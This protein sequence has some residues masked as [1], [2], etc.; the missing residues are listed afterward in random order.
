MATLT[1]KKLSQSELYEKYK[2]IG[3]NRYIEIAIDKLG[4]SHLIIP[5]FQSDNIIK[6]DESN[7]LYD[8]S[9]ELKMNDISAELRNIVIKRVEAFNFDRITDYWA[10]YLDAMVLGLCEYAEDNNVKIVLI[11]V[12]FDTTENMF[13]AG[14]DEIKYDSEVMN[15]NITPKAK[16]KK[17]KKVLNKKKT[18]ENK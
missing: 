10:E 9:Q 18:N 14:F 17:V 7:I 1:P 8:Y 5:E 11:T 16:V 13:V 3:L 6:V 12:Y 4:C 15:I 2:R